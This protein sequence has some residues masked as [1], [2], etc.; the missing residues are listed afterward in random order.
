MAG[1][2]IER[3][4]RKYLVR[5]YLGRDESGKRKHHSKTVKGSRRDAERYL[6]Q[7]LREKDEGVFVKPSKQTVN[8]YLDEWLDTSCRPRVRER[9][10]EDYA[11]ILDRYVRPSLGMRKLAKL[12]PMEIQRLYNELGEQGLSPRSV[13]LVH[14]VLNSALV[15][16]AKWR[17]IP[18]NPAELVDLPKQQH[19]EIDGI[20]G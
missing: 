15:Q 1:Q 3:G 4:E 6:T 2:I 10:Y 20:L 5:M 9:T 13:R 16:A 14:A 8:Q 18:Q 11:K 12:T 17:V 19:R 7:I